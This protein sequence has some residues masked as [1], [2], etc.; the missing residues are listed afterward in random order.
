[1]TTA[2]L[3]WDEADKEDC[4]IKDKKSVTQTHN[5]REVDRRK[6]VVLRPN[7]HGPV[8]YHG[9]FLAVKHRAVGLKLDIVLRLHIA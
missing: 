7:R 5:Q 9:L 8:E 2:P 3:S 6:R 4:I 1:M